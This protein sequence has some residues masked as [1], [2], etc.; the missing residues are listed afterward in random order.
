MGQTHWSAPTVGADLRVRPH[1]P[2][3]P[4]YRE[5]EGTFDGSFFRSEIFFLDQWWV[6]LTSK[7]LSDYETT[8]SARIFGGTIPSWAASCSNCD[9]VPG[10]IS[11][12]SLS[13]LASVR[14]AFSPG[15]RISS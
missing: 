4:L 6:H 5:G 12:P 10:S 15:K 11:T 3:L 13:C 7:L 9:Q 8:D 14:R 2:S 1:A